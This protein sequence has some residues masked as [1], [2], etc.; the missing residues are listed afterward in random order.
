[1]DKKNIT[2]LPS[3]MN[4]KVDCGENLL[5]AAMEAGIHINASCGGTGACGKCRVRIVNG[6]VDS[7][8]SSMLSQEDYNAGYRLA[9]LSTVRDDVEV[10]IP[11]ESQ[12]DRSVLVKEGQKFDQPYLLSP[13]DIFQLVQGWDVEPTVFKKYVEMVPPTKDDNVSDLTR[14]ITAIKKQH[15]IKGVSTDFKLL[16]KMS[17]LLRDAN[18]KVTVTLVQTRRGYKLINAEQGDRTHQNY[19]IVVDIGTTTIFGQLL[20]LNQDV[21]AACADG[22]CDGAKL[23]ALAE[24]SDY[25]PQISYG[26]DVITRI[27]YSQKPGGLKKLQ[28]VV[29]ESINNIIDELLT[30]SGVD[31]SLVSHLVIA[32]NTTMTQLFLGMDPKYLRLA[33]YVPTANLIPP[34]RAV[35]LGIKL[36]DH[37]HV[38]IFPCVASYV[39]GDIVAGVLGSGMFQR[40]DLTLYMDI[41]TNGEIVVGNKDWLAS[42]S[43]SA[44]PAFEGA[45]I[46]FGMRATRGAI[47]EVSINPNTYEPMI[48]TIGRVKPIGI[49]GSGLIDAVAQLIQVGIIDQA[50][51]FYRDLKTERVRKGPDGYEYVLAFQKDTRL[52]DD[53]VLTEIDIENLIRTKGSIYAGCKVLLQSVGLDFKDLDRV[54]IAG[55][56][57]RHLNLEKAMFIGLLPEMEMDRFTFVGNGSLLG[58]RLLSFSKELLQEAERIAL[59]MTNLELSNYPSYMDE[60]VAALFLP[61]T[62]VNAFPNVMKRLPVKR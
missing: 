45:G 22:S 24:A 33:P 16:M 30:S 39:G 12:V 20:D 1:M 18:W 58:A 59:M 42:D 9:C 49:C 8:L 10:E 11:I 4:I 37:V 32:A 60:F 55:G 41:G 48:L 17:Q 3:G 40:P 36:G 19:S 13:K 56:F 28:E 2:F 5:Q 14:L 38:Y 6:K 57:G 43:C 25:N 35:H 52:N 44:G 46:K 47:E 23:F 27:V 31:V 29:V 15:D 26:E 61:H 53:I 51:K 54:I 62:D 50:G 34:M 21:K 7:P